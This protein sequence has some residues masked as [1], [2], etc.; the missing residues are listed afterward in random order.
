[1]G[2]LTSVHPCR[3]LASQAEGRGRQRRHS[4]VARDSSPTGLARTFIMEARPALAT[5]GD[6]GVAIDEVGNAFRITISNGR[7]QQ[8]AARSGAW[9][10]ASALGSARWR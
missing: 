10:S 6:D 9:R 1:M 3:I 7:D 8:S 5:A 2:P 4:A